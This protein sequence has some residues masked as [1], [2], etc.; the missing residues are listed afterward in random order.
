MRE[1]TEGYITHKIFAHGAQDDNVEYKILEDENQDSHYKYGKNGSHN[2]PSQLL[3]MVY[4]T[5]LRI[6]CMPVF[7]KI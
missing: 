5:H 1:I 3:Q 2:M 6:I 4:E 7:K